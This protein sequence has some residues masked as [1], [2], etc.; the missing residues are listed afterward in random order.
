FQKG[1]CRF[2]GHCFRVCHDYE[3][4]C[5]PS[6]SLILLMFVMAVGSV[7]AAPWNNVIIRQQKPTRNIG[8]GSLKPVLDLI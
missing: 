3:K 2:C 6:L 5:C 7:S 4:E 1:N 8:R